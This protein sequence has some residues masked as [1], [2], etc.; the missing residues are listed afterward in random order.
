MN[1]VAWYLPLL[2]LGLVSSCVN[3][4]PAGNSVR[5][6]TYNIQWFSEDA[7]PDRL[8]SL[9]AIFKQTRPDVVA[10]QE[11]QSKRAME[12]I[13][14][15][16]EWTLG[17]EDD[18]K[19]N[20]EVGIAVRAPYKLIKFEM[21]FPGAALDFAFPGG[22][23]VLRA[24]IENGAGKSFV[25]YVVHMKSRRGSDKTPRGYSGRGETDIQREQ[26]C[27]I[28]AGYLATRTDE[29]SIVL[30]DFNDTPDD[31]SLNILESGNLLAKGGKSQWSE[32]L[33]VN[34]S[35]P[36]YRDDYVTIDLARK[37]L[38]EPLPPR[39]PGAM[40]ANEELRGKPHRF[41]D[42]M[43]V[44]QTMFDQIVVRPSLAAK[45]SKV[46]I[47]SGVEALRG[48]G[49]RTQVTDTG[50]NYTEKGS[51]ASD[52]LPVYVDITLD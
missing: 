49:G 26:A 7:N 38:G 29:K 6:M 52:H 23:N 37:F 20:Q 33:M 47:F 1:R 5:V 50:V 15:P 3:A 8:S 21:L 32:P 28:L 27:G 17:M 51:M 16:G 31:R 45:A 19:E 48:S 10:F 24:E 9:N 44:T 25:C 35:E 34:L 43:K 12:Q 22:R 46:Q 41:P 18:A 40:Q 39:V 13:F 14:K 11:V 2:T 42:D 4:Q 36:L 30:G